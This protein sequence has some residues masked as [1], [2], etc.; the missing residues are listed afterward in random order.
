MLLECDGCLQFKLLKSFQKLFMTG[1]SA[2]LRD[3]QGAGMH[4][5]IQ[6]LQIL[7]Y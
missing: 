4:M 5:T 6:H 2:R 1:Q 7:Q 3:K